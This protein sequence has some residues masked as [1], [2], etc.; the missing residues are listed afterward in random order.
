MKMEMNCDTIR[1]ILPHRYPFL[2]IDRITDYEPGKWAKSVKCVSSNEMYFMGHFPERSVMP[3]VL[4]LEAMAQ[5]GGIAILT[6][7]ENGGKLVFLGGI[8]NARFK[9]PVTPGDVL[10]MEM[11]ITRCWGSV[12]MGKGTA[13]VAGEVVCAAEFTF[14][15]MTGE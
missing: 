8:K 4:I 2:L 14:A 6:L 3:G 10:E 5:T 13:M 1:Q 12:G 9:T 11:E 7:P 15:I